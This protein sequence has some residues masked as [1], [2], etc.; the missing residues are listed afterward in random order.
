MSVERTVKALL[1][2]PVLNVVRALRRKSTRQVFSQIYKDNV[3]ENSG[4]SSQPF[5]SG[6]G[7]HD[8]RIVSAY[9]RAVRGFLATFDKKPDVVDLGCGDFCVGSQIRAHCNKYVACDIVPDL[10]EFNKNKYASLDVD[11]RVLDLT[12]GKLPAGDIVFVRQ[13]LQ[14]LSNKQIARAVKSL[15]S[16]Y[17]YLVLTEH[18]PGSQ[19]FVHNLDKWVG[20]DIRLAKGSGVVLTSPPFNLNPRKERTLCQ[21]PE[22]GGFIV[23]TLYQLTE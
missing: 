19:N 17:K 22:S 16:R 21:A 6:S 18:L 11:F 1:P 10:I 3:W 23:T 5:Y 12:T 14:H 20:P 4:D 15:G 7:S 8:A 9:V 2:L 13:V